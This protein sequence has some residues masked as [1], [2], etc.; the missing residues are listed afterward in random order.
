MQQLRRAFLHVLLPGTLIAVTIAGAAKLFLDAPQCPANYTQQQVDAAGCIVGANI[1]LGLA[2][3]AAVLV[4]VITVIGAI[5]MFA[6]W[7]RR[8][9]TDNPPR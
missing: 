2:W 3:W 6:V 9:R 4:E 5:T 8:A 7:Q 1:G